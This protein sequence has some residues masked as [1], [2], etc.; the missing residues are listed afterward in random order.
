MSRKA[1]DHVCRAGVSSEQTVCQLGTRTHRERKDLRSRQHGERDVGAQALR[2]AWARVGRAAS[3]VSTS[4]N[5]PHRLAYPLS[6]AA[7]TLCDRRLTAP[8]RPSH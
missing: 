5:L 3:A 2:H 7:R 4:V 1:W 8:D 6:I